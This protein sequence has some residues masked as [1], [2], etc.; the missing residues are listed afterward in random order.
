MNTTN[1]TVFHLL[2]KGDRRQVK[3]FS[4]WQK[5]P[6]EFIQPWVHNLLSNSNHEGKQKHKFLNFHHW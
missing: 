1:Q 3:Y 6:P 4:T 5:Q 2:W